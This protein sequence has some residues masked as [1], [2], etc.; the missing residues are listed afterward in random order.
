MSKVVVG[1]DLGGTYVRAGLFH[2]H[3]ELIHTL[4]L[5]IEAQLGGTAGVQRIIYLVDQVLQRSAGELA[6]IGVGSTGPLDPIRGLIQNP[7]TLPGWENVPVLQPL[8]DHFAVPAVLENDADVAA[9]GEYWAGAGQGAQRLFAVTVGTGVG[10]A[11]IYQ[12]QIFRGLG[13]NHPEGGHHIIDPSGPLCYCGARGC[14]ESLAAAPAI[15]QRA[16]KAAQNQ[17]DSL[18]WQL[19]EGDPDRID[20]KLVSTAT[21][22]GDPTASRVLDETARYIGLGILNIIALFLPEMIVLSGGVM[23]S[24]DLFLPRIRSLVDAHTAM[25]PVQHV[26]IVTA[27]LG[28]HAGLYGAAYAILQFLEGNP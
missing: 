12:G 24:A 19:A 22:Q 26:K 16:R 27:S 9:L 14:W 3:G 21:R 13:G 6:G 5:P 1:I 28:Y 10:T 7:Y 23:K 18:L 2:T 15:A 20:A 8:Q 17:V 25:H 4:Q 11:Y